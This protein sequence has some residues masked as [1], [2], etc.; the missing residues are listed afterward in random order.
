MNADVAI[1]IYSIANGPFAAKQ[2]LQ[3]QG[4][5]IRAATA[6]ERQRN[7]FSNAARA[8]IIEER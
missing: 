7:E 5:N 3:R 4:V 8:D 1:P 2:N 6:G